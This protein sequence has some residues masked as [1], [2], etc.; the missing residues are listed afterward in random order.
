MFCS[1]IYLPVADV[2]GGINLATDG[3]FEGNDTSQQ[4]MAT[5]VMSQDNV[6][7]VGKNS[8]NNDT[9]DI[10][11]AVIMLSMTNGTGAPMSM[12]ELPHVS[13]GSPSS[14]HLASKTVEIVLYILML[15]I[16]YTHYIYCIITVFYFCTI[17]AGN[18]SEPS[19]L[20]IKRD[21]AKVAVVKLV[22]QAGE[23]G[24][25]DDRTQITW[26]KII[27]PAQ[28]SLHARVIQTWV[29]NETNCTLANAT[30]PLC[31]FTSKS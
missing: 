6:P 3:L 10:N 15:F 14:Y 29:F 22:A 7:Y 18:V 16:L 21:P 30:D 31:N 9:L 27:L 13:L 8:T 24:N 23:F 17:C 2:P 1:L 11:S 28:S 20:F 5:N 19:H 4:T 12:G 25:D 26:H